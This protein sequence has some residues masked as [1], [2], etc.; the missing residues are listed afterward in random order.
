MLKFFFV[1]I[2]YRLSIISANKG[3]IADYFTDGN[4]TYYCI[5][6]IKLQFASLGTIRDICVCFCAIGHICAFV[7]FAFIFV[8]VAGV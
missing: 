7:L 1:I 5:C 2:L 3:F 6:D 4:S 8:K